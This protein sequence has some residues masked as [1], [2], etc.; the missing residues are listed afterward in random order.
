MAEVVFRAEVMSVVVEVHQSIC[1]SSVTVD[2]L[3]CHC[4]KEGS[5]PFDFREPLLGVFRLHTS[6][7]N[8]WET[9]HP[10]LF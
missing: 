4:G 3:R 9:Q 7:C 5:C 2:D 6:P 10:I 1:A 8:A